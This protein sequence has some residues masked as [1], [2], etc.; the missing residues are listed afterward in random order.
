M[1]LFIFIVVVGTPELVGDYIEC[2]CPEDFEDNEVDYVN[3]FCWI[4]N[5]YYIP[6]SRPIPQSY[7]IRLSNRIYYY[8]WT[9]L[10]FL[11]IAFLNKIPRAIWK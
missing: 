7:E 6:M 4:S 11:V 10:I 1:K 5:T 9:P 3:Y 8:Q 2:W